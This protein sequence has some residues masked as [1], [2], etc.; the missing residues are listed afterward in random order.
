M[1]VSRARALAVR[2]ALLVGRFEQ[3]IQGVMPIRYHCPHHGV[4]QKAG[5][6]GLGPLM[7]AIRGC[8]VALLISPR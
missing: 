1:R 2:L 4:S 3:K 6:N 7:C 8:T 5:G